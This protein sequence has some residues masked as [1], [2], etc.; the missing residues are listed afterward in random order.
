MKFDNI[1]HTWN[2]H[3]P[4]ASATNEAQLS[5]QIRQQIQTGSKT[6]RRVA[7]AAGFVSA[8][9]LIWVGFW[10]Y[11]LTT[12]GAVALREKDMMPPL[13]PALIS[14]AWV[15]T[16]AAVLLANFFV[17]KSHRQIF[18]HSLLGYISEARSQTVHRIFLWRAIPLALVS[19]VLIG[20]ISVVFS[21][22]FA[23]MF[24]TS[25]LFSL[26]LLVPDLC[27][28]TFIFLRGRHLIRT[29]HQPRLHE[30]NTLLAGF[31]TAEPEVQ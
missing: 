23:F 17:Q 25:P 5:E 28:L 29:V 13:G 18:G 20:G 27:I 15:G 4:P 24:G 16:L 22:E 12:L 26:A 9:A 8:L 19:C 31:K 6:E 1:M 2:E 3:S 10:V 21:S 30:I 7:T 11:Q 14:P